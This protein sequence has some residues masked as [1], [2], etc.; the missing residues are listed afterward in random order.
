MAKTGAVHSAITG[1]ELEIATTTTAII[2]AS[3][4]ESRHCMA[5]DALG[6][7]DTSSHLCLGQL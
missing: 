1:P 7:A 3:R 5:L 6:L 4:R 2:K